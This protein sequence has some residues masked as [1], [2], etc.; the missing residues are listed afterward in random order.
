[1]LARPAVISL[2]LVENIEAYGSAFAEAASDGEIDATEIARL[3]RMWRPIPRR[4]ARLHE[5]AQGALRAL[6][7]EGIY[8]PWFG[9]MVKESRAAELRLVVSNDDDPTPAGPANVKAA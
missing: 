1:M 9:R 8:G 5:S 2:P 3:V 6:S 4:C 7:G